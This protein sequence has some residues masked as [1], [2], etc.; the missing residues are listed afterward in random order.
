MSGGAP[1][2]VFVWETMVAG[3]CW[4]GDNDDDRDPDSVTHF[5][6]RTIIHDDDSWTQC[7]WFP[8]CDTE[9]E[10]EGQA[11]GGGAMRERFE[12]FA[13]IQ[14][15]VG[16]ALAAVVVTGFLAGAAQVWPIA[17]RALTTLAI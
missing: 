8:G 7:A 17:C 1:E 13:G 15:K 2:V 5:Q 10:C 6:T 12:T 11:T 3:R 4:V 16:G 14:E 9:A